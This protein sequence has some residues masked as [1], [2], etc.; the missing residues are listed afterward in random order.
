MGGSLTLLST[1]AVADMLGITQQTVSRISREG[2]LPYEICGSRRVYNLNDIDEYM[3]RENLSR[4]PHDHPR[5]VD[6][7]PE[8]TAISFF[9]GALGLDIGLEEAGVPILLHAENDTKCRM[10]IDTNS[11]EA[12]LLGDVNSLGVEQVRTYAR[13]PSGREVDV[14]VGGPPCQ[15]FST[16]GARRAFD[17][18]RGNVFLR[19]LELAEEIQPRYLV[20]ENVRGLLST[21][22]PLKPGGNPVHG[23]ALRLILNR[24]KS[25]GYG[26][27]FNLYNS[28][29]FGSPQMRERII[30]VGKRDGTIAPWLTPTNSSDPIWSLPQWR[31]FREAASSIDGEQH[32]TQ[33]PDKRLRYFKMLSEGQYWKDLPKNAQALAMGK[34]YRLSGGKTGFYRRIWWDKPCPTLVTSPT[35]PATDLCHPT[36]NRPLSIEEYRAVQEF[37]KNWI[38]RGGLTDMYRQLGNAVPIA[39]GKAVGQTILNDM[40]GVDTSIPYRD[41]PYSRYKRTSNITWKMP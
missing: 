27:S 28:A 40:I 5:M 6:D 31:T 10:T 9:S 23:G 21:A 32:F 33:F 25:M 11:P 17:D 20:I 22:Y 1:S 35:M 13:I 34:A 38:V 7:L 24:L 16:A 29:N 30:V 39:L 37:P 19:F 14:M 2:V 18:A 15:S 41:F 8:I 3:R 4:A 36:E 26:V 12:A